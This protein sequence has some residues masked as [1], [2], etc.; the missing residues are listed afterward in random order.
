MYQLNFTYSTFC[1]DLLSEQ[2]I[3]RTS[4]FSNIRSCLPKTA[5]DPRPS[6]SY[7]DCCRYI[8]AIPIAILNS[9]FV[10]NRP[11]QKEKVQYQI[12]FLHQPWQLEQDQS[13]YAVGSIN[14]I[15]VKHW[16]RLRVHVMRFVVDVARRTFSR[17]FYRTT[18]KDPESH[19]T[20]IFP[21]I[22][23]SVAC[24][25]P[26]KVFPVVRSSLAVQRPP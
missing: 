3:E 9:F 17:V 22:P 16:H 2:S 14:D 26:V 11:L 8:V 1:L 21:G 12:P 18:L 4:I 19:P 10:Q 15:P 20:T 7:V 24:P 13:L 23:C 6:T 25:R 5:E